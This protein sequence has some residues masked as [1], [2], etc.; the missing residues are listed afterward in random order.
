MNVKIYPIKDYLISF[1]QTRGFKIVD[2]SPQ[3]LH[4]FGNDKK[5][6]EKLLKED[7]PDLL[8]NHSFASFNLKSYPQVY[9]QLK[10][11]DDL[12][13]VCKIYTNSHDLCRQYY[14]KL[15]LQEKIHV[16]EK[17]KREHKQFL[18][19]LKILKDIFPYWKRVKIFMNW[20]V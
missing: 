9:H 11:E 1:L 19:K 17:E 4:Y 2:R 5:E 10:N 7:N 8:I 13:R 12:Y 6:L 15:G 3:V 20:E 16:I 18:K 14:Q